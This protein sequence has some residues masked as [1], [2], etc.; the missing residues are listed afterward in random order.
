MAQPTAA[1]LVESCELNLK[2]EV[3]PSATPAGKVGGLARDWQ[4]PDSEHPEGREPLESR[5][6]GESNS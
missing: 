5:A 1:R 2:R 6:R 4:A 3:D